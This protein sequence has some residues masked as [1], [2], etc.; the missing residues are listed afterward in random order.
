MAT[1]TPGLVC[2]HRQKPK[3]KNWK[4]NFLKKLLSQEVGQTGLSEDRTPTGLLAG[5]ATLWLK[6]KCPIKFSFSGIRYFYFI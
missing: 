6:V 2:F 1:G 3:R 4:G 5:L